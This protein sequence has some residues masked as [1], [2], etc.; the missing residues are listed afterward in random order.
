MGRNDQAMADEAENRPAWTRGSFAELTRCLSE[1]AVSTKP[2]AGDRVIDKAQEHG[3]LSRC[4][5]RR[6]TAWRS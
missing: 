3:S 1:L 4:P 6:P 2:H 5:V